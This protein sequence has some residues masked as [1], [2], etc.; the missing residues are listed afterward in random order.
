MNLSKLRWMA[1]A[2]LAALALA[3]CS[4]PE[5]RIRQNPAAFARL[6]SQ[7]QDLIRH[8]QIAVGFDPEMVQL[9]LGEPDHIRTRTDANG[10]TEIWTYTTYENAD[11]MMLYRGWYHRYYFA[12][13][14][15]PYYLNYPARR[16]HE[17]LRVVFRGGKVESVEQENR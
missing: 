9:S 17:H 13:P 14:F 8:G 10:S 3:A 12:D 2:A 4:T 6:T 11:G 1:F 16:E 5:T 7:Q 15:F